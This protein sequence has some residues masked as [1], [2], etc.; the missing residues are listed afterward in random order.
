MERNWRRNRA[1]TV[2]L[3]ID[4]YESIRRKA[5][6]E[7]RSV[8]AMFRILVLEALDRRAEKKVLLRRT[9]RHLPRTL[10]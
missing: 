6:E 9:E 1:A 7:S 10:M 2:L 5:G 3:T 8:S 4:E